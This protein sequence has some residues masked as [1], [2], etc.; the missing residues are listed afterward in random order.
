MRET[1]ISSDKKIKV[2]AYKWISK[3]YIN[4]GTWVHTKTFSR[5]LANW[6]IYFNN[7]L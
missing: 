6:D 4:L 7:N 2:V 3:E 1:L 5:G